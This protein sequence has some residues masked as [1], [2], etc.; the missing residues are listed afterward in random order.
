MKCPGCDIETTDDAKFCSNCAFP[1]AQEEPKKCANCDKIM[2]P[3]AQ[4]CHECGNMSSEPDYERIVGVKISD[5]DI[6]DLMFGHMEKEINLGAIT[7]VVQ[8][9]DKKDRK[10]IAIETDRALSELAKDGLEI[11][12][13]TYLE[14]SESIELAKMIKAVNNKAVP[15]VNKVEW[16]DALPSEVANI[17]LQR[18]R[19]LSQIVSQLI[20]R[21]QVSAF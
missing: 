20:Q 17:A 21:N 4:F 8:T 5:D 11:S 10:D 12:D 16:V 19:M 3:K 14:T 2:L 1:L 9:L 6:A 13:R 7:I 15:E 18:G